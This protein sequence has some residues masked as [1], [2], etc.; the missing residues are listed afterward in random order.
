MLPHLRSVALE[1]RVVS[2]LV[3]V[4]LLLALGCGGSSPGGVAPSDVASTPE[5]A[6]R[7]FLQAVADSNIS[8]MGRYWGTARGPASQTRQPP[9]YLQRLGITQAFLRQSP[10][11]ILRSDPEPNQPNRQT[12]QVEFT[13]TDLDGKRCTRIA[14][15]GVTK[16]GDAGWIISDINLTEV[17]TPGRACLAPP[18][19][20]GQPTP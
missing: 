9:D 19:T 12:V 7:N 18:N 10:Y 13:R 5:M 16:A 20:S 1:V 15:M 6:V 3:P 11:R 8:L 4:C 17:G 2:R 14:K